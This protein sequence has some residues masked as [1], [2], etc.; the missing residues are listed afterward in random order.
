MVVAREVCN[1][2]KEITQDYVGKLYWDCIVYSS[3][4]IEAEE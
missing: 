1:S 3:S 4:C 2:W